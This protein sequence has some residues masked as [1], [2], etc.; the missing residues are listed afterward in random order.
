[1]YCVILYVLVCQNCIL[2]DHTSYLMCFYISESETLLLA[3]SPGLNFGVFEY[4]TPKN[5]FKWNIQNKTPD[6][7]IKLMS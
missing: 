5:F 4:H 2:K 3:R 7:I 6:D 1:M